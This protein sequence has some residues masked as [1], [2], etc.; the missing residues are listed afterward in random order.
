MIGQ[1]RDGTGIV[2]TVWYKSDG[3]LYYIR[4][5]RALTS[6]RTVINNVRY[7][8]DENGVWISE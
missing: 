3:K 4:G 5:G 7:E 1:Y 6:E 8:F 2:K